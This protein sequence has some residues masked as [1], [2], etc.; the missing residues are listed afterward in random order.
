MVTKSMMCTNT[1]LAI[2]KLGKNTKQKPC[3]GLLKNKPVLGMGMVYY[4]CIL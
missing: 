1:S 3:L 2:T 4:Y